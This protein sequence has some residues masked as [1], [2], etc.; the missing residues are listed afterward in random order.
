MKKLLILGIMMLVLGIAGIAGAIPVLQL[1]I[2][3]G[4]YNTLT[5]TIVATTNPFNLFTYLLPDKK[6]KNT[7]SDTYYLSMAV[8][9]KTDMTAPD[10]GSF[11]FTYNGI[12][13]TINVTSDMTYGTP[14][15]EIYSGNPDHDLPGHGIFDTYFYEF[16]FQFDPNTW[17]TPYNTAPTDPEPDNTGDK[18]YKR[19]FNIDT[20]NLESGY[21]IHFDLYNTNI[22]D[23]NTGEDRDATKFAPF[24]HDAESNGHKVPEPNTLLL[25][26]S[27]L[28]GLAL[29]GRRKFRK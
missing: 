19:I 12:T 15:I 20:T 6:G 14:P 11:S 2:E 9:P 16:A 4:T 24:S 5:E 13:H 10:L 1:D 8:I 25:L 29:Y 26:G 28:L 27:G 17:V 23:P 21:F 3:N 22:D 7:T 18:M